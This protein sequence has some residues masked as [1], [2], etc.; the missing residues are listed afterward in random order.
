MN[1]IKIQQVDLTGQ[2]QAI[3]QE[4][5]ENILRV[6]RS[7]RYINGMDVSDFALHLSQ[8]T[9]AKHVIP[10]ANGTDALQI[11]LMSL[12]IQPGD[13]VIVPSFNYIASAEAVA[14]LGFTPVMADVDPFTFNTDVK[15]IESAISTQTRVVIVVHLFGQICDMEPILQLCRNK[16]IYLIEDNAQ[17]IGAVYSFSDGSKRQSGTM[18]DISTLSF[19]PTKN[20][21]CFGDGGAML[22]NDDELAKKLSMIASHGQSERY[23]HDIIGCNSRLDTLQAAVLNVKLRYL[24]NYILSRQ[25]AAAYYSENLRA[26]SEYI[27]LPEISPYSTHVYNQYTIRVKNRQRDELKFF[28][29]QHNIPSMIYYPLAL[30]Q[31]GA[32]KD[33]SRTRVDMT[34]S[35]QLPGEVLSLP[36]HTELTPEHQ[37]FIISV[38]NKFFT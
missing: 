33:I 29:S 18:G 10:C 27:I 30:H 20:L 6:V 2:Y 36:M 11:A 19:F 7:G 8:Y 12:D 32:L 38:I 9:G 16:G 26:L 21:G 23:K 15:K 34:Y 5:D 3:Q 25:Q 4:I 28:L 14:L 22:T 24:D 13:E 35:E 31:Q 37:N 1:A 17:S